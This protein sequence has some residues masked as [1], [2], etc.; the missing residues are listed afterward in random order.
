MTGQGLA[1]ASTFVSYLLSVLV[2]LGIVLVLAWLA[3]R[4]LAGRM[5]LPGMRG[6]SIRIVE[7]APLGPRRSLHIVEVGEKIFLVGSSEGGISLIATL[8]RGDVPVPEKREKPA[9][10]KFIDILRGRKPGGAS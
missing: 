2:A 4:F 3:L 10:L 7:T 5:S 6:K 8:D 9:G 1:D